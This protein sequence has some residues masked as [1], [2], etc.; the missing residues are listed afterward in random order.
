MITA[1]VLQKLLNTAAVTALVS[2]RIYIDELPDSVTLPA[3]SINP[4]SCIPDKDASK[5]AFARVQASC[6]ADPGKPKNPATIEAVAAAVKAA[7]HLP[8]LNN[9][10]EKWTAG[11]TSYYIIARYCSGGVRFISPQTGW[12]HVPVDVEILYNEEE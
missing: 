10:P 11:T 7:L 8:R 4:I 9:Q 5:G 1:M 3:I 2:T 12:Y 6:W